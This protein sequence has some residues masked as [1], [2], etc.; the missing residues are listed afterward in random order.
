MTPDDIAT[1]R[2][3]FVRLLTTDSPHQDARRRD[4]NQAIFNAEEGWAI[5]TS[6]DLDMVMAKFDKAARNL[7][8]GRPSAGRRATR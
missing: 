2:A 5:W 1:L 4:F 3:E 6:T 8:A 7:Q